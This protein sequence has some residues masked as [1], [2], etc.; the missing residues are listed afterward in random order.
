MEEMENA[1][2]N[3]YSNSHSLPQSIFPSIFKLI[4]ISTLRTIE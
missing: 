2:H 3:T 1:P 4:H